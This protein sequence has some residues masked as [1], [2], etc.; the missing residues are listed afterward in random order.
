MSSWIV[1]TGNPAESAPLKSASLKS[2]SASSSL[3][4]NT[5]QPDSYAASDHALVVLKGPCLRSVPL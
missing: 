5:A 3:T 2:A 4:V 1:Y